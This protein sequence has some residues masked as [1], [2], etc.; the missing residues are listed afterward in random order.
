[1]TWQEIKDF[2]NALSEEELKQPV[3]GWNEDRTYTV[4]SIT[5]TEEDYYW[6]GIQ[7]LPESEFID[8][9]SCVSSKNPLPKGTIRLNLE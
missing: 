4:E 6:D 2:S 3:K 9:N 5:K 8:F 7:Y 1:M